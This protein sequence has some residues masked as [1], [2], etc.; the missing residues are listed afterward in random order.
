MEGNCRLLDCGGV[1]LGFSCVLLSILP[2]LFLSKLDCYTEVFG[3]ASDQVRVCF[4]RVCGKKIEI[5]IEKNLGKEAT[6][7]D[8]YNLKVKKDFLERGLGRG[9]KKRDLRNG[10]EWG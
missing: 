7:H 3:R 9:K 5:E 6:S 1:I 2:V 8:S 10:W 4:A